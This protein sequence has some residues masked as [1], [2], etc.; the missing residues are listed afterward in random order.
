MAHCFPLQEPNCRFTPDNSYHLYAKSI[1]GI[2]SGSAI[3]ANVGTRRKREF[4]PEEQKDGNYWFKR[5]RNN[6]AAKRSRQRKRMEEYLLES[7]AVQLFHENEKLKAVLSSVRSRTPDRPAHQDPTKHCFYDALGRTPFLAPSQKTQERGMDFVS[8]ER[9]GRAG[10]CLPPLT[11]IGT[12]TVNAGSD[13]LPVFYLP[14]SSLSSNCS[15]TCPFNQ[16]GT[17]SQNEIANLDVREQCTEKVYSDIS[18][19]GL[20]GTVPQQNNQLWE[21]PNT[22]CGTAQTG[23][24]QTRPSGNHP[25]WLACPKYARP[26]DPKSHETAE[27]AKDAEGIKPTDNGASMPLLPHKLRFKANRTHQDS[28]MMNTYRCPS[29]DKLDA[30][31]VLDGTETQ[32]PIHNAQYLWCTDSQ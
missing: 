16:I 3:K 21:Y 11:S 31:S 23:K 13:I 8:Y 20:N 9:L 14:S 6:E 30:T 19:S 28:L 29:E 22:I 18:H 17:Y 26:T 5:N 15:L 27:V 12:P 4:I 10:F 2:K 25:E 32:L 24:I 1:L 7:R